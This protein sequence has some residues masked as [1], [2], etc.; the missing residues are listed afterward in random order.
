MLNKRTQL[1]NLIKQFL[2]LLVLCALLLQP[3]AK[4][5]SVF[6]DTSFELVDFDAED[7]S[8]LEIEDT[9]EESK[10]LSPFTIS[11]L[12]INDGFNQHTTHFYRQLSGSSHH[13]E[14]LIPPPELV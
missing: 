12:L 4:T 5:F 3:I 14:I 13:L 9:T 11:F 7:D 2:F 6:S 8:E 10:K 1:I